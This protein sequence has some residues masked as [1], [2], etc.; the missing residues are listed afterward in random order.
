MTRLQYAKK[1]YRQILA[2]DGFKPQTF[3]PE[4]RVIEIDAELDRVIDEMSAVEYAVLR[5]WLTQQCD[6]KRTRRVKD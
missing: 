4:G 5:R 3:L 2:C 1:L 6:S